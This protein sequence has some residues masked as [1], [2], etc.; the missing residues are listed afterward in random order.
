MHTGDDL[1]ATDYLAV[2]AEMPALEP[3]TRALAGPDAADS[4]VTGAINAQDTY[5]PF[6]PY[7]NTPLPGS[8]NGLN[9][10]Q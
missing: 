10:V 9:G 8:P 3:P 2:L 7:L 1:A 5:L 4:H 6:F